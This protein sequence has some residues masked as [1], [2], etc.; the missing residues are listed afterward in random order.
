[1]NHQDKRTYT[2]SNWDETRD[3]RWKSESDPELEQRN[4]CNIIIFHLPCNFI[5]TLSS[6][7][8]RLKNM[9]R[10]LF[11]SA[12]TIISFASYAQKQ[13]TK[14]FANVSTVEVE[15]SFCD[16]I[17][18]EVPGNTVKFSG[19]VESQED[20][21]I[22][23]S[24]TGSHVKIWVD[25]KSSDNN[26]D[27]RYET[28]LDFII[29]LFNGN[30][31]YEGLLELQVPA[32][33]NM[34]VNNS[35]GDIIVSDLAGKVISLKTSSGSITCGNILSSLSV[36]TSSGSI[37][38]NHVKG[39]LTSISSSGSQRLYEIAGSLNSKCSSGSI[40]VDKVY[41]STMVTTSSG[42]IQVNNIDSRLQIFSTSGSIS[43]NGV[44][45]NVLANSS[46]G[47][48]RLRSVEGSLDIKTSSGSILGEYVTL[49]S[50]SSFKSSSGRINVNITNSERLSYDLEAGS[51][52]LQAVG[53]NGNK[54]LYVMNDKIWVTG[55][56]SSGSQ[57]FM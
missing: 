23:Y 1:M 6:Y 29:S 32:N 21:P 55:R 36:K 47:S 40:L 3:G 2:T 57:T 9:K 31:S 33:T 42:R 26:K 5:I 17:I 51:G 38:V 56:S 16:V 43:I 27:F 8:E 7:K 37:R 39:N 53:H 41:G 48:V 25:S 46:S 30:H 34:L 19:S 28:M 18:K 13:I 50:N 4:F 49:T 10:L 52:R 24:Q 22:R 11:I 35:S 44:K 12:I 20:R 45:G 54:K 15:G 14:T